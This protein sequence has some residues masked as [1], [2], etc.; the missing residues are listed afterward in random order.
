MNYTDKIIGF[1]ANL[2]PLVLDGSKTLTYRLGDKYDFLEAGDRIL[3][4]NS[5]TGEVFAELEI[6]SKEK[7]TFGDLQ[8]DRKGHEIFRSQEDRRATFEKYYKR[9][10]A[11]DEPVII[12][13]FKVVRKLG[14]FSFGDNPAMADELLALVL[15]GKKTA[16]TKAAT[17]S[18]S[19]NEVGKQ[20]IVK[21]GRG[22]PRAI[23]EVVEYIRQPFQE[24]DE[25]FAY[26]EGEGDRTLA[27]WRKA[28]KDFFTREGTY[29][30][31]M[32]VYCERFNLIQVLPNES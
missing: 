16:T 32:E 20:W 1:A 17:S 2:V 19:E 12:F 10:V 22:R 13:G 14:S 23:I 7:G 5:D 24:V 21:D 28:H 15:A 11:N 3:T 29:S 27:Y 26:D 9:P 30:D 18:A 8:N 4:N 25:S 6:T 31:A